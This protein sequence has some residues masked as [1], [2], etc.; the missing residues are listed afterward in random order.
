MTRD[1]QRRCSAS[2][3]P[4]CRNNPHSR[5]GGVMA[6][7]GRACGAGE[8]LGRGPGGAPRHQGICFVQSGVEGALCGAGTPRS[9]CDFLT[10]AAVRRRSTGQVE[11]LF[12]CF[13]VARPRLPNCWFSVPS[14]RFWFLTCTTGFQPVA[15]THEYDGLEARRTT[16]IN[17]QGTFSTVRYAAGCRINHNREA[18]APFREHLGRG[19]PKQRPRHT[20]RFEK[21]DSPAHSSV[22][23]APAPPQRRFG[24]L[25]GV[26][27]GGGGTRLDARQR[28]EN[29]KP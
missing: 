14:A 2:R 29:S 7:R 5:T 28:W 17:R 12:E 3:Q 16:K 6:V 21:S 15:K 18:E 9:G 19:L 13:R 10:I 26:E 1:T 24:A 23:R 27:C 20:S 25:V 11:L 8:C 22:L 4:P